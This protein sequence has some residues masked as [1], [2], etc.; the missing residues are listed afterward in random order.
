VS[1]LTVRLPLPRVIAPLYADKSPPN[2]RV[3]VTDRDPV[4]VNVPMNEPSFS[5]N[6]PL[7]EMVSANP[8]SVPIV[9]TP[10][11]VMPEDDWL[12]KPVKV[13]LPD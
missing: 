3:P 11:L 8:L 12:T 10:A 9:N 5:F 4:E 1:E 6:V 7:F 2:D 13:K